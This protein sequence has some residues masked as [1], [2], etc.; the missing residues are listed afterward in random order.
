[1]PKSKKLT[2]ENAMQELQQL[3]DQLQND[4]IGIDQ[5]SEKIKRAKELI[6]YCRTTLRTT[7]E[8]LGGLFD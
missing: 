6:E 2:Y 5:L 3:T 4:Q 1:M 8:D 7:E